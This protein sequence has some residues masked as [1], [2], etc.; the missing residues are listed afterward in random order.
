MKIFRVFSE[1]LSYWLECGG[2]M[3]FKDGWDHN[4]DIWVVDTYCD[5][6]N[7]LGL[8]EETAKEATRF[9]LQ[10]GRVNPIDIAEMLDERLPLID[11]N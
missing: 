7:D 10:M 8:D 1:A 9:A 11:N 4:P 6:C 3:F 2:V 5:Y